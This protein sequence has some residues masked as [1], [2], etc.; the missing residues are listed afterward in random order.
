MILDNLPK[1]IPLFS[2]YTDV[3]YWNKESDKFITINQGG[4]SCFGPDTLVETENGSKKIS[5]LKIGDLVKNFDEMTGEIILSPVT[6]T[7]KFDNTKP[8]VEIK[9][10]NGPSIRCTDD[11]KFYFQGKWVPI[12]EILCKLNK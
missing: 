11:H 10:K 5:E 7:F 4:T 6:D 3:Y 1:N 8:T 12:K 2:S 9:F